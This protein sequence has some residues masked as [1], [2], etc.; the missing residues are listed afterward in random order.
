MQS[1]RITN[2]AAY[3][4]R[5]QTILPHTFKHP[6]QLTH[7]SVTIRPHLVAGRHDDDVGH[8]AD[9]GKVEGPVVRGAVVAWDTVSNDTN[10]IHL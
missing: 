2:I 9:V 5:D 10:T 8:A 3:S 6:H 1:M 4:I 7:I